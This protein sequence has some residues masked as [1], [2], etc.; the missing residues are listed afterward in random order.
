MRHLDPRLS[1]LLAE[2]KIAEAQTRPRT[3]VHSETRKDR[4]LRTRLGVLLISTGE[5]LAKLETELA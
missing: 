3:R 5:R 1:R 2:R 4:R